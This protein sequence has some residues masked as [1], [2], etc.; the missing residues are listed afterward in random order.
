MCVTSKK[1]IK[2]WLYTEYY[3]LYIGK[4]Q[5]Q[6]STRSKQARYV[7]FVLD[8]PHS[9]AVYRIAKQ[10]VKRNDQIGSGRDGKK[11]FLNVTI[12]IKRQKIFHDCYKKNTLI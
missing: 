8:D 7:Y 11:K 4:R 5:S 12:Y 10:L 1:T 2:G 6:K 9:K 3:T